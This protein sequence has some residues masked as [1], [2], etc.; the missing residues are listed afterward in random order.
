MRSLKIFTIKTIA[1]DAIVRENLRLIGEWTWMRF[2]YRPIET[3]HDI[4]EKEMC[5]TLSVNIFEGSMFKCCRCTIAHEPNK[6]FFVSRFN[7]SSSGQTLQRFI[8]F[9]MYFI[10]FD[11]NNRSVDSLFFAS[12]N[13]RTLHITIQCVRLLW[14]FRFLFVPCNFGRS[15]RHWRY[16]H[17][18][19]L[20]DGGF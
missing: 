13:R 11:F 20:I 19:I 3:C 8:Q 1:W 7:M 6:V 5:N 4:G 14:L 12:T 10:P 15:N 2:I 18:C 16:P 17:A 9:K